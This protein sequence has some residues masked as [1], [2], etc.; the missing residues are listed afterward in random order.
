MTQSKVAKNK[1]LVLAGVIADAGYS[2]L[3]LGSHVMFHRA[4]GRSHEWHNVS[5]RGG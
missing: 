3:A 1:T 4:L 2:G 5:L